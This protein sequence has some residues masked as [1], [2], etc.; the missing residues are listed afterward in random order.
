MG[1]ADTSPLDDSYCI[2]PLELCMETKWS[3]WCY[4]GGILL[5]MISIVLVINS[6]A[7]HHKVCTHTIPGGVLSVVPPCIFVL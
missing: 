2:T 5:A 6:V 3:L 4:F 1:A 7:L